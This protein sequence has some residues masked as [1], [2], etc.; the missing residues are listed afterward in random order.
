M[1]GKHKV[2]IKCLPCINTDSHV[3]K[4]YNMEAPKAFSYLHVEVVVSSDFPEEIST[5]RV[6][7]V[8]KLDSL[9]H[10]ETSPLSCAPLIMI[11]KIYE[12]RKIETNST[13][14]QVSR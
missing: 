13:A 11:L 9:G 2:N 7:E 10:V 4:C 3:N 12:S 1:S 6:L 5:L 8:E 14:D